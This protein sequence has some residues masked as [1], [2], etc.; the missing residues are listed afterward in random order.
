MP[1]IEEHQ[2]STLLQLNE[3]MVEASEE[4]GAKD[5][6]GLFKAP[7]ENP[8]EDNDLL[9]EDEAPI[10]EQ[11]AVSG[12]HKSLYIST[13]PLDALTLISRTQ[14]EIETLEAIK[15]ENVLNEGEEQ[16]KKEGSDR[17]KSK[18][19]RKKSFKP[20]RLSTH[21]EESDRVYYEEAT[22]AKVPSKKKASDA[23]GYEVLS[24]ER[25]VSASK[26]HIK[27]QRTHKRGRG[28]AHEEYSDTVYEEATKVKVPSKKKVP[29]KGHI[30]T[31]SSESQGSITKSDT[32]TQKKGRSSD[33]D[34]ALRPESQGS[35][36]KAVTGIK[37]ERA[38]RE[39]TSGT[40]EVPDN[41]L[42]HQESGLKFGIQ[43]K[44][45]KI[46]KSE[47]IHS[48]ESDVKLED[49][50]VP[51][52]S[53]VQLKKKK[54]LG[55][56]VF[57][58]HFAVPDESRASETQMQMERGT[59]SGT[60]RL[61]TIPL[62]HFKK[63]ASLDHLFPE[64]K[65]YITRTQSQTKKQHSLWDNITGSQKKSA[66]S[67]PQ[68]ELH[69]TVSDI[70]FHLDMDR[71]VETHLENLEETTAVHEL[72]SELETG[73]DT[74]NI[75]ATSKSKE[76]VKTESKNMIA[77]I[78]KGMK[79][80]EKLKVQQD[81]SLLEN[82][83][84]EN[85]RDRYHSLKKFP[86]KVINMSPFST[87]ENLFGSTSADVPPTSVY[88]T[89]RNSRLSESLQQL[90]NIKSTGHLKPDSKKEQSDELEK[91]QR[92]S[93]KSTNKQTHKGHLKPD[94]KKEQS[95][96]L[97]KRQRIS[98]KSTN[99]QTYKGQ[100]KHQKLK[101]Q[102]VLTSTRKQRHKEQPKPET[103]V[104]NN[105]N[106][107]TSPLNIKI[108]KEI[109]KTLNLD[110]GDIEL[111]DHLF[112][113]ISAVK[114]LEN[115]ELSKTKNL[116]KGNSEDVQVLYMT[117]SAIMELLL[118]EQAKIRSLEKKLVKGSEILYKSATSMTKFF[119]EEP[120]KEN[121]KKRKERKIVVKSPHILPVTTTQKHTL[122]GKGV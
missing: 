33:A 47:N 118:K 87:K 21:E 51:S 115:K 93:D 122:K 36:S 17:R 104:E 14:S 61:T 81:Q 37:K 48:E 86:T 62:E 27:N 106:L 67:E 84:Q 89:S 56:D 26:A 15:Y 31:S 52:S 60:S 96:E 121:K 34:R 71:V 53:Q 64:K 68:T 28:S 82:K 5:T 23:H 43:A 25:K 79:L 11:V 69:P 95:D 92:I 4:S 116:D 39:K 10:M 57:T 66:Q 6:E 111:S 74:K 83:P 90:L 22:E 50:T 45:L 35:I 88:R 97:E 99:K 117:T 55:G 73:T 32:K 113:T 54:S 7:S 24:S 120:P 13:M 9:P 76:S 1:L 49:Q 63:E 2:E 72:R 29:T 102:A 108:M 101:T 112:K 30:E 38:K 105:E 110:G 94:S 65:L 80:I 91:R 98:D 46:V 59:T 77:P 100:S 85:M 114:K 20:E 12:R 44:K 107:T 78:V 18:S 41:I 3:E 19:K 42:E 70:I 109:S 75:P 8:N 58:I 103:T 40:K 16:D 119:L